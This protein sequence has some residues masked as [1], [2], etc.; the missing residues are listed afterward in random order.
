[1]ECCRWQIWTSGTQAVS[2][3]H[4]HLPCLALLMFRI[5]PQ[6]YPF[7]RSLLR[8][9]A[10]VKMQKANL[11][12][13]CSLVIKSMILNFYHQAI[14]K[15]CFVEFAHTQKTLSIN[16]NNQYKLFTSVAD[17]LG[18]LQGSITG[19]WDIWRCVYHLLQLLEN[20]ATPHH[21]RKIN[22]WP[23]LDMPNE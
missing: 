19:A 14:A 2:Q 9:H 11:V 21:S 10:V 23:T 8:L 5:T 18:D 3:C 4:S 1:M 12:A 15:R 16:W 17:N 13:A 6:N 20:F 7:V 22:K